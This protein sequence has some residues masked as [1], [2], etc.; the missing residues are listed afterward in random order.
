MQV[1]FACTTNKL[2]KKGEEAAAHV[3]V[4][5]SPE[6]NETKIDYN[7]VIYRRR[8]EGFAGHISTVER[9]SNPS[10]PTQNKSVLPSPIFYELEICI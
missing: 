2:N 3:L 4:A 5:I 8:K 9:G 6:Y 10:L 1:D 7:P